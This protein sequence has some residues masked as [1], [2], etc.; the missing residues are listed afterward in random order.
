[1]AL[2]LYKSYLPAYR[3][4][5]RGGKQGFYQEIR[6]TFSGMFLAVEVVDWPVVFNVKP[7]ATTELPNC[8]SEVDLHLARIDIEIQ[9]Q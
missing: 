6:Q 8:R 2:T 5:F 4:R 3:Y 1:M 9:R 7:D